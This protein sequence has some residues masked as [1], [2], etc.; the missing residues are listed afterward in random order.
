MFGEFEFGTGLFG[1]GAGA[2]IPPTP[3]PVTFQRLRVECKTNDCA[4][5]AADATF[6]S[7]D[8]PPAAIAENESCL[9]NDCT[10]IAPDAESFS[11][12]DALFFNGTP[13]TVV[14][15]CPVGGIGCIPG[16]PVVVTY[17]P[18]TFIFP[19]V[20]QTPGQPITLC[21]KGCQ[22]TVCRTLPA[23]ATTAQ[24]NAAVAA[25]IQEVATQQAQCDFLPPSYPFGTSI[26]LGDFDS[27]ACIN[28]SFGDTIAASVS[29]GTSY[30]VT[31]GI[32]GG[33]LPTGITMIANVGTLAA[34]A[35]T[36]TVAGNYNFTLRGTTSDGISATRAYSISIVGITTSATLPDATIGE[37]YS[38]TLAATGISGTLL[39]G[40]ASGSL[41]P[42]L[43]INTAT[44]EISGTP[45]TDDPFSFAIFVQNSDQVC[46]KVF[47]LD[48]GTCL[49]T[50]ASPLPDGTEDSPYSTTLSA[51]DITG[52]LVWSII[53]GSLPTGLTLNAATGEISGTP[54]VVE[55]SNFTTQ[56]VNGSGNTC[57]KAFA[58]E[59]TAASVCPDWTQLS[60]ND[61]GTDYAIVQFGGGVAS[62]NPAGVGITDSFSASAFAA[63]S[64]A[65]AFAANTGRI[66]YNGPGCDCIFHLEI[67][68][69]PSAGSVSASAVQ[70]DNPPANLLIIDMVALGVGTHDL[71]FT[72]PD[73][74]GVDS[75]IS[76]PMAADA[77]PPGGAPQSHIW[78]ASISNAP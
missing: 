11:L 68:S 64:P 63:A 6:Y 66:T 20:P 77:N 59:V 51:T 25:I 56:V 14:I 75:H 15:T 42:G 45:T 26:S 30:P 23:D 73:S 8:N 19:D 5:I 55:T 33:A 52:T 35:G 1:D 76:V 36:P 71:P 60:W 34:F 3:T 43:T 29:P 31:F 74:G 67:T 54:T 7:L 4:G 24:I 2:P 37:P 49:I 16:E 38:V 53:A 58:L 46:A 44:G 70:N 13:V 39:W 47:T 57:S 22:S 17:P 50:T 40:I 72:I 18:G 12:Q 32:I 78:S 69:V 62:F 28:S 9:T 41:P 61:N 27:Y 48:V 65:F 10:G 21:L